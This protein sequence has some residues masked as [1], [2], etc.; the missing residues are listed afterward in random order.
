MKRALTDDA[1]RVSTNKFTKPVSKFACK[2]QKIKIISSVID[3]QQP[4]VDKNKKQKTKFVGYHKKG[5]KNYTR[6]NVPSKLRSYAASSTEV[7]LPG[8][9]SESSSIAS[10]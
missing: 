7:L 10:T 5:K 3:E 8:R 9:K 6:R 4:N 2:K 1:N